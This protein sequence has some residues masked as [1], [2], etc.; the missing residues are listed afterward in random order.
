MIYQTE[1]RSEIKFLSNFKY[2]LVANLR[3]DLFQKQYSNRRVL[4]IYYDTD[5]LK[6]FREHVEG[7][8]ERLKHRLRAYTNFKRLNKSIFLNYEIKHKIFNSGYKKK[9]DKYEKIRR[10]DSNLPSIQN[11]IYGHLRPVVAII[12]DREYYYSP[13]KRYRITIDSNL[14]FLAIINNRIDINRKVFLNSF[15]IKEKKINSESI[16]NENLANNV[17]FS[18]YVNAIQKLSISN[19]D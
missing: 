9:I 3:S 6:F 14:T 7:C 1:Y 19:Y 8:G 11:D 5:N 2:E 10:I 12:Y 18:K 15:Y 13:I 17:K 4:S 16:L